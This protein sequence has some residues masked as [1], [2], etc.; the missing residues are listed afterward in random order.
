[1]SASFMSPSDS[2]CKYGVLVRREREAVL[3]TMDSR[4]QKTKQNPK[5]KHVK[6]ATGRERVSDQV[7]QTE[8]EGNRN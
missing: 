8:S 2:E 4:G 3:F 7:F 5:D 6:Q 1:M